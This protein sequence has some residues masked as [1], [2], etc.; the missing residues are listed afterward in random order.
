M[1]CSSHVR[2]I[3]RRSSIVKVFAERARIFRFS[4]PKYMES[5][6]SC[7]AAAR[8]SREPTGAIIS[9][10]ERRGE[11][12]KPKGGERGLF[13]YHVGN[14]ILHLPA[15]FHAELLSYP[16]GFLAHDGRTGRQLLSDRR[17]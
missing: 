3:S 8:D 7:M 13:T 5:A 9:K 10:S 14:L 4:M 17:V 12:I 11:F 2:A 15:D 1:P 6:P 16:H